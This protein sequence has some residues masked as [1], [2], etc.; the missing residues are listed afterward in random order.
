MT[1]DARAAR[2]REEATSVLRPL[3]DLAAPVAPG[4]TA[5]WDQ[6]VRVK[7]H[8]VARA[9]TCAASLAFDGDFDGWRSAFARRRLGRQ[10]LERMRRGATLDPSAL[11]QA[12]VDDEIRDGRSSLA[13]W[14]ADLGPGGRAAVVRDA[15]TFA[16][17]A[18]AELSTWPPP[19]TRFDRPTYTWEL[20]GRAV[21]L[22]A[23]ADAEAWSDGDAGPARSLLLLATSS[24][25][26]EDLR[27]DVAWIAL[28][29]TLATGAVPLR[30]TRIDVAAGLRRVVP[31]T[32]DVLDHGLTVAATTLDAVASTRFT[33]PPE[34]VPGPWCGTCRG[35]ADCAVAS[36]SGSFRLVAH[37]GAQG[38][39]PR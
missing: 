3:V 12:V 2:L 31:V 15:T 19:S 13:Q 33:T 11:A 30:V 25:G 28:V 26:A 6:L 14:L 1:A 9:S 37:T 5:P 7:E 39:A 22:E 38:D 10:V 18:R 35:R 34:P 20:V 36:P 24:T 21:R 4:Q 17:S 27:R 29:V 16:V 23:M 8:E 32:D